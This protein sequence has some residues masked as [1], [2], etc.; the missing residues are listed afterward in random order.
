MQNTM[1]K[2]DPTDGIISDM[3]HQ[4]DLMWK[5]HKELAKLVREMRA[6]GC[7]EGADR[8]RGFNDDIADAIGEITDLL[9]EM[10]TND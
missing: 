5:A 8:I 7:A 10:E 6:T 3:S 4:L 9:D 1:E 2:A